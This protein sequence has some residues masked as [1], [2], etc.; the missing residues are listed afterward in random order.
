MIS[1]IMSSELI[2][3]LNDAAI[4]VLA[5]AFL[6]IGFLIFLGTL[7]RQL[8]SFGCR[9]L[10]SY[11]P[12]LRRLVVFGWDMNSLHDFFESFLR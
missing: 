7:G 12:F 10:G 5:T 3:D 4:A 1:A 8:L 2:I 6:T 9:R 11:A